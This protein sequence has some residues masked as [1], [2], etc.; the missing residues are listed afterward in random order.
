MDLCYLDIWVSN[1]I[2][3]TIIKKINSQFIFMIQKIRNIVVYVKDMEKSIDFYTKILGFTLDYQSEHWSA[4]RLGEQDVYVGLHLTNDKVNPGTEISF[5]VDDIQKTKKGLENR[6]V[7]FTRDILEI[8]PGVFLS[9][10]VDLNNNSLSI[11][12][13][14]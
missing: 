5:Q 8:A 14:R 9:N 12:Q 1:Y 6:G 4:I 3:V 11:N 2:L 13:S 10:F 7:K